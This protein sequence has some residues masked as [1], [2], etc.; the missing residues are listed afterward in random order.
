MHFCYCDTLSV[1]IFMSDTA[2]PPTKY[3]I[4][5]VQSS[6][7]LLPLL[8][9]TLFSPSSSPSLPFLFLYLSLTSFPLPPPLSL[10]HPFPLPLPPPFFLC[11]QEEYIAAVDAGEAATWPYI[12]RVRAH[13]YVEM[14]LDK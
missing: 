6:L 2:L 13:C 1:F 8:F 11:I 10:P 14:T 4:V 7:V 3:S 9:L 5:L 12:S